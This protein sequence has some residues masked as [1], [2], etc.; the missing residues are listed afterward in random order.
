MDFVC[1]TVEA[2]VF[3]CQEY[4]KNKGGVEIG[5]HL[6]TH[7]L[8]HCTEGTKDTDQARTAEERLPVVEG[9]LVALTTQMDRIEK[10]LRS[11]VVGRS[12]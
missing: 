1:C 7:T 8:V 2:N 5:S 9:Q 11:L 6:A 4:D 12:V 3:V 10:V